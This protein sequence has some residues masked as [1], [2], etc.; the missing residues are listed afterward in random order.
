MMVAELF[1]KG[2]LADVLESGQS[3]T[4]Q[5]KF[6]MLEDIARGMAYLHGARYYDEA[7]QTYQTCIIH[8]CV[9]IH[10]VRSAQ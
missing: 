2:N 9:P 1:E 5:D 3:L 8:R 4:W 7:S 6:N 10:I